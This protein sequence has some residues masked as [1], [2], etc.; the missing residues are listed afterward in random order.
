MMADLARTD[1]S[2]PEG[3]LA[4]WSNDRP[5]RPLVL[6]HGGGLDHRMW[7]Q[8]VTA[9]ADTQGVVL[10]DARGH[11]ESSTATAA[12][13]HCDD[14]AAVFHALD[15]RPATVVGLSVVAVTAKEKAL[16]HPDLVAELQASGG[17]TSE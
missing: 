11:G 3:H 6:L 8:Q 13:R 9:F 1:V 16:E 12:Y 5:G 17:G 7:E 4:V 15:L 14:L 2:V 10:V